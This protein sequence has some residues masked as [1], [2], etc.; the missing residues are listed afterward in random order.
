MPGL[1]SHGIPPAICYFPL[2]LPGVTLLPGLWTD[3]V[4][5]SCP[6]ALMAEADPLS[7]AVGPGSIL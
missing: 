4:S 6:Q 3:P 1:A 2:S 7:V 5:G